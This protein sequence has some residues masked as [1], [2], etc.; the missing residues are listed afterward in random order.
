MK[1]RELFDKHID[2]KLTANN[3]TMFIYCG[4]TDHL[5]RFL[6]VWAKEYKRT[7]QKRLNVNRKRYKNIDHIYENIY[8]QRLKTLQKENKVV[9]EKMIKKL[10]REWRKEKAQEITRLKKA[11][12]RDRNKIK[13]A[14]SVADR[15]IVQVYPSIIYK[16]EIVVYEGTEDGAFWDFDEFE[17]VYGK[18][19]S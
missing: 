1:V 7:L 9:T 14:G 8:K 16:A 3:G 4:H 17:E 13:S 6:E 12:P 15:D 19:Y 11:I 10:Q 5:E 18:E 2:I